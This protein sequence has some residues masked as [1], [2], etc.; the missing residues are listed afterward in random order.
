MA[1]KPKYMRT[2]LDR[3]IKELDELASTRQLTRADFSAR[4]TASGYS[5]RHI[6]RARKAAQADAGA[7]RD[8]QRFV[9]TETV[10]AAVFLCTG[11]MS[12]AY[13]TLENAGESLPSLRTFRRRVTAE[14]GSQLAYARGGSAMFRDHQIYLRND[15]PHRMHSVL[16]D[17]TELPIFVVPRGFKHA[18]KP[19]IT[20]VM[21]GKTRYILSYVVTFGRP[22]SEQVRASMVQAMTLRLAPDG[23]TVVGGR[24]FKAVWDR[25]LEFLATLV[26]ES[27]LRLNVMPVALPAYSPHLKG[28]L[29]RFWDT[30]KADLLPPLPGYTDGPR[31]L[32]GNSALESAAL[33]EE[34][35]LEQ[36]GIWMDDYTV[37]HVIS[38]TGMTPLQMWQAD[39][40]PL[41]EIAPEQ[42]WQDFLLAKDGCKVSKNGIRFDKIDWIAPELN[43]LVGRS[44]HIRYL[45][46]DRTF[47]EVFHDG[48]HLCTAL[49]NTTALSDEIKQDHIDARAAIR[50]QAQKRATTANRMR[51]TNNPGI[52]RLAKDKDGNRVVVEPDDDLLTGGNAALEALFAKPAADRDGQDR[53]F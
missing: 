37:A 49:P 8:L 5:I 26:T 2:A 33:G 51:R 20:G 42:L 43:G 38:T 34:E 52:H 16:L 45:P 11:T 47:V 53:L 23:E 35:F 41:D 12:L 6:K 21:D 48:V 40:T 7:A 22:S 10:I 4:S 30:L 27:C 18:V 32:R 14:L 24:P 28:R 1:N 13:K 25:G 29:E 31:D 44:V 17:H 19:W 9:V 3:A 46:H 15:Y 50:R 36:L 39:G